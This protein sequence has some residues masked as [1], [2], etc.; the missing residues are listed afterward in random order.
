MMN[1]AP[2]AGR[3]M[4]AVLFTGFVF[5]GMPALAGEPDYTLSVLV[6]DGDSFGPY[7]T[8][9]N[10]NDISI[11]DNGDW[12]VDVTLT[13]GST[14]RAIVKNGQIWLAQGDTIAPGDT[15]SSVANLLKDLNNHGDIAFRPSLTTLNSGMYLNFTPLI[16]HSQISSSPAFSEDTPYIGFFRGR[17]NDSRDVFMIATVND[18]ELPGS[19]HRAL[20]WLSYDEKTET[21][22]ENVLFRKHDAI[23]GA[24]EGVEFN[25]AGTDSARFAINNSGDAYF[26]ASFLNSDTATNAALFIN[27]QMVV[28]KGDPSPIDGE[29]FNAISTT[30][31]GYMN[32]D[33]QFIF[34]TTIP[35]QPAGTNNVLI[36]GDGNARNAT[37]LFFRQGDPAPDV[38][39]ETITSFGSGAQPRITDQGRV[40]WWGMMTGDTT[41]NVGLFVDDR[42]ILRRGDTVPDH[43]TLTTVG[44]TTGNGGIGKAF[45]TS[46]SGRNVLVRVVFNGGPRAALLVQFDLPECPEDLNGD[47]SV[48]V[49]DLL[50]LLDAWGPC[51]RGGDC[52]EDLND[53]GAVDVLDLLQLLD[54]WGPC[55]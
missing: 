42:L 13:G 4:S 21:V 30:T 48:D 19:V 24:E 41:Q 25:D 5:G 35:N 10:I 7:G 12:V 53:D 32:A 3:A 16:M 54:A 51:P 52:P 46:N 37:E 15:V 31:R 1:H 2:V 55:P 20:V 34:H 26:V 38:P 28:R 44:G 11:N 36:R 29:P 39:G 50:Q 8:V 9:S 17:V 6:K 45:V 22:T 47:G 43:G 23:P 33:R 14:A 40:V 49:L 18:S 27:D